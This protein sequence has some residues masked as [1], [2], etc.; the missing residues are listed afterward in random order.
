MKPTSNPTIFRNMET[1]CKY[2]TEQEATS[3]EIFIK[4]AASGKD[5][6]SKM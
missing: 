4:F 5:F 2:I 6:P 1:I 3:I